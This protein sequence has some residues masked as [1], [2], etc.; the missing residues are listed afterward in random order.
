MTRSLW[1]ARGVATAAAVLFVGWLSGVSRADRQLHYPWPST[2]AVR[3][4][5]A[6][7][8]TFRRIGGY[9]PATKSGRSG[10]TRWRVGREDIPTPRGP[11]GGAAAEGRARRSLRRDPA[12]RRTSRPSPSRGREPLPPPGEIVP[13]EGLLLPGNEPGGQPPGGEGPPTPAPGEGLPGLPELPPEP[14]VTRPPPPPAEQTQPKSRAA[15]E[16]AEPKPADAPKP[17]DKAARAEHP[18]AAMGRLA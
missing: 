8:A 3:P 14:D 6:A 15:G 7:G 4:M 9:G 5:S 1:L 18:D 17:K 16:S 2:T 11:R 13:P 12:G 10:S